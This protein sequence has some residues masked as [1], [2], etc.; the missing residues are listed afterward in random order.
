[1]QSFVLTN[2]TNVLDTLGVVGYERS[3]AERMVEAVRWSASAYIWQTMISMMFG[4]DLEDAILDPTY[5]KFTIGSAIPYLGTD[6]DI[7]MSNII[8]WR[9]SESWKRSTPQEKYFEDVSRIIKAIANG[10]KNTKEAIDEHML[11]YV[12]P[13]AGFG[14]T[15]IASNF[16]ALRAAKNRKETKDKDL[17]GMGRFESISGRRTGVFVNPDSGLAW[18]AGAV[19]GKKAVDEPSK[20]KKERKKKQ[21]EATQKGKKT[22]DKLS[23][24]W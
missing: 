10:E 8:P 23:R 21:S 17:M 13:W 4:D 6:I 1:M 5:E 9:D 11:S 15:Q 7:G 19:F 3:K 14:G 24:V 20:A 22:V 18:I 16:A 12:I 2:M